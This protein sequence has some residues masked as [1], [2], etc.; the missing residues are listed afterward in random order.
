MARGRADLAPHL[1]DLF[2]LLFKLL[3]AEAAGHPVRLVEVAAREA[4]PSEIE[5]RAKRGPRRVAKTAKSA[6]PRER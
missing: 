4:W 5:Q 3:G 6:K 1:L 2:A